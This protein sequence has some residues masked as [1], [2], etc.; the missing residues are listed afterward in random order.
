MDSTTYQNII[1]IANNATLSYLIAI[2]NNDSNNTYVG[3][4]EPGSLT[5]S[6]VW[7][8][9]KILVSGAVTMLLSANGNLNFSNIWDN[10]TFLAYS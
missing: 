2:D 6:A 7:Q 10:R 5:S 8:I 4:A 9:R 3:F 1:K